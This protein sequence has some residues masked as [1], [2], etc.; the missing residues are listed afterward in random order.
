MPI[1]NGVAIGWIVT[2]DVLKWQRY[3]NCMSC[4]KLNSNIRCIE[5]P[6][7]DALDAFVKALNS[8]IRCIE[9]TYCT[10]G[11]GQFLSW[12]VTLDVLKYERYKTLE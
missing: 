2:L 10:V 6:V 8:N 4:H 5:M 3:I 9:M 1:V 12:I 7:C 11:K